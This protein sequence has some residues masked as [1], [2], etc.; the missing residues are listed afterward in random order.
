MHVRLTHTEALEGRDRVATRRLS[1]RGF[2]F[3]RFRL[4]LVAALAL[5]VTACSSESQEAAGVDPAAASRAAAALAAGQ[6]AKAEAGDVEMLLVERC[7]A[8][9]GFPDSL[10]THVAIP[11][12]PAQP[13]SPSVAD[14]QL[15]GYGYAAEDFTHPDAAGGPAGAPSAS[16]GAAL[17]GDD[18]QLVEV[19][20]DDGSVL[21]MS[22]TG[23]FAEARIM[24]YG[25][26]TTYLR[27]SYIASEASIA[28]ENASDTDP[29]WRTAVAAW[30]AC[31][32]TAGYTEF[33]T[34]FDARSAVFTGYD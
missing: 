27:L 25:D 2:V 6:S 32:S 5:A 3:I 12:Q 18:S 16:Y 33:A 21:Q 30:K 17:F 7:M 24:L 23:C 19:R 9:L 22:S 14:A 20:F 15:Y 28:D 34:P 29:Q 11:D 1:E 8:K 10:N 31:M 26:L 4:L 13:I